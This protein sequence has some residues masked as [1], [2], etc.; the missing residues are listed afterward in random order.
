MKTN[1]TQS[2]NAQTNNVQIN[3]CPH[4]QLGGQAYYDGSNYFLFSPDDPTPDI[5]QRMRRMHG[6]AQQMTD[7][8]FDF[9]AQPR[10]RSQSQLI[11]K[12]AHGRVSLTKDKAI[13]L[14][15]KVTPSENIN[16]AQAI[17]IE[18]AEAADAIVDYQLKR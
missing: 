13:Q 9:V 16:I 18:S 17:A 11:R 1:K 5:V 8:T 15:L 10:V 6:V 3:N 14:T 4:V 7:G 2:N 12:L